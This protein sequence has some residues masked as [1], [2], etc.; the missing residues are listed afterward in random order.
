MV[1]GLRLGGMEGSRWGLKVCERGKEGGGSDQPV[2]RRSVYD[3]G[4][5]D[6][7]KWVGRWVG[8]RVTG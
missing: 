3:L 1:F 8:G 7:V 5:P 4:L 6:W 2:F